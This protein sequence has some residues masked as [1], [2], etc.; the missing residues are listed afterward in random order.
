LLLR[1]TTITGSKPDADRR[2]QELGPRNLFDL[3]PGQ[4][5]VARRLPGVL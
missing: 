5:R 4:S 2:I 1:L 3:T